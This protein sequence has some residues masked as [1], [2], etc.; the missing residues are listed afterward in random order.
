MTRLWSDVCERLDRGELHPFCCSPRRTDHVVDPSSAEI[1]TRRI[2]GT[3]Q[4]MLERS[5]HVATLDYDA[6]RIVTETL[7]FLEGL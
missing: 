5:Y 1:I 4:R 3:D 7:E 2:P 6:D